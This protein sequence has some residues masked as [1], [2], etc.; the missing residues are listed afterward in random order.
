METPIAGEHR[1]FYG[2]P[3][4]NTPREA[5]EAVM[6]LGFNVINIAN[7][8]MLDMGKQGYINQLDYWD[9]QDALYIGGYRTRADFENT[10]I[11]EKDGVSIAWVS[12]TY[13]T[14]GMYLPADSPMF[15]PFINDSHIVQSI[16]RAKAAGADLVFASMHWGPEDRFTASAEQRRLA[17]VLADSGADVIIGH[18]P[19]VLQEVEWID[20]A[21]YPGGGR[22]LVAYSLSNLISTQHS[23]INMV[24][25][26]L[27]FDIVKS[28]DNSIA[29]ENPLL[30]PVMTHYITPDFQNRPMERRGL[31][32]YLIEN[33]TAELLASHGTHYR[34]AENSRHPETTGRAI[35]LDLVKWLV[36]NHVDP[37]FLPE[38]FR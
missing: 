9:A 7:N 24:G 16:Q 21:N 34:T 18:H 12:F 22:A 5:A 3:N 10:R 4:F 28:A 19:H 29:I 35:T 26:L 20:R 13:G 23:L 1:S 11:F 6:R 37:E 14:N 32:V 30:I 8:H 38:F 25:G 36:T 15:I 31:Q 27:Q 33:Y 17:R 2:F